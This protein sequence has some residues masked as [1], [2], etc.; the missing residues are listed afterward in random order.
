MVVVDDGSTDATRR[1][2]TEASKHEPRLKL[3]ALSRNFGH[4]AALSAAL[5]YATGDAIVLMDGDLQDE[6]EIIPERVRHDGATTPRRDKDI[7]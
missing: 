5:D 7:T 6:P 1:L 3:V 2:L 4:Q